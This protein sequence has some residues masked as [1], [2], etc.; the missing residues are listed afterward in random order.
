MNDIILNLSEI[1][2]NLDKYIS[3]PTNVEILFTSSDLIFRTGSVNYYCDYIKLKEVLKL[4]QTEFSEQDQVSDLISKHIVNQ[5]NASIGQKV[6]KDVK[7]HPSD[8]NQ[9]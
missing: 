9:K 1:G 5:L 8:L 6:F 3:G 2:K 7:T 4:N